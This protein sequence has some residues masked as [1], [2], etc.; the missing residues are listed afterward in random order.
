[1]VALMVIVTVARYLH[2]VAI[3][4]AGDMAKHPPLR[5][6]AAVATCLGGL[7]LVAAALV[8]A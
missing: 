3:I 2:A 1:M 6:I 5:I 8:V 4:A 7:G